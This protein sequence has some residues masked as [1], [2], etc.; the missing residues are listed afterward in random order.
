MNH[1]REIQ[2]WL[3][4]AKLSGVVIPSAD[5]FLSKFPPPSYRR[6]QWATGFT[7]SN[8]L[9]VVL[10]EAAALFLD[11]RYQLQGIEETTGSNIAIEATTW[12]SRRRWLKKSLSPQTR[13][14]LDPLCHSVLD[15]AQW[16]AVA[17]E[18][19]LELQMLTE[20]PIDKLWREGRPAAHQPRVVDY[21]LRYSGEAHEVK[22]ARLVAHLQ[23]NDLQSLL[24][25]D[26]EDVSWLLNVR[27]AQEALETAVGQWPRVPAC[28]SRVLIDLD[29]HLTWFVDA[30]RL[31]AEVLARSSTMVR[32][33]APNQLPVALRE[34]AAKGRVG[35][36][37][38]LTP[39]A[40]AAI[41]D[42]AGHWVAD[43]VVARSRWRKHPAE[44][45]SAKRAHIV[46]AA[47]V[48]RFLAWLTRTT[49]KRSVTEFEAAE[50]L[51]ALRAEHPEYQ[52]PSMPQ[53]SASGSSGAQPH[54]VP[55]PT[56]SRRLEDHPIYW[57]DSGGHYFGGTT[58]NTLTWALGAP[59][60]KHILAHTL[61]LKGYVT[62]ATA[63]VPVGIYALH[64]DVL[65][66]QALWR[67]GMDFAHSTG[68]SVGN[69]LSIHEGLQLN[70]EPGPTT[71]IPMEPGFIVTNEP[72]YYAEGDF[73]MRIESH[74]VVVPSR[75]PGFLEFET[76]SRLPIDPRLVDF[77]R[78]SAEERTW[79]ADYHRT[80]LNE[81]APLLD[82][83]SVAWLRTVAQSFVQFAELS[84]A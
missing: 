6:L 59:E 3:R 81:L 16:R 19:G 30:A 15:M 29:G 39:A 47:A 76:I 36:D 48:V 41:I 22:C 84:E 55:Y 45:Q 9:A 83:E 32:I 58:D 33:A 11:G 73:G 10:P 26:S 44:V 54:Y 21:P 51:Q 35:L 72:G 53:M 13:I 28:T 79:L 20:N 40:L 56:R 52:A 42:E 80:V 46:D 37:P 4:E 78:L 49:P 24:V 60:N 50:K 65:A 18:L 70:R 69:Y 34:R 66:R 31:D 75:H 23:A 38:R 74:M 17:L 43:D 62:F 67:E 8:G 64:L 82:E 57:M 63:C 61:I 25:A 77:E 14:A 7:G 71:M 5:E 68:H 2:T 27:L 12:A 1:L